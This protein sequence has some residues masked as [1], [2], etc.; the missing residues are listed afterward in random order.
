MGNFSE[1]HNEFYTNKIPQPSQNLFCF[2]YIKATHTHIRQKWGYTLYD[3]G[4]Q[5]AFHGTFMIPIVA[6]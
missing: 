4:L 5:T 2:G 1:I 3:S 6:Q